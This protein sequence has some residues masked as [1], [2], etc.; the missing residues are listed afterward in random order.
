M[1]LLSKLI[2]DTEYIMESL[3]SMEDMG[4]TE[5]IWDTKLLF[6]GISMEYQLYWGYERVGNRD[7]FGDFEHQYQ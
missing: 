3:I 2:W 4:Y 1:E 7:G 6:H 5:N